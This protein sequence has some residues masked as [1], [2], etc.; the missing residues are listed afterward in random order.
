MPAIFLLFFVY[1]SH[2]F[3]VCLL[4]LTVKTEGIINEAL[5]S[6]LPKHAV[7]INVARGQHIVDDDLIAALNNQVIRAATLDV[8]SSEP[9]P[10][11]HPYW[12]HPAITITPHCAALSSIDSV[13]E[14]IAEN[15]KCL[16]NGLELKYKVDRTKGY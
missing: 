5:L 2:D 7:L 12:S 15:A 16:Q 3:V 11:E 9:L 6:Q 8:F 4:P 10:S 13:A 1:V 14:Q